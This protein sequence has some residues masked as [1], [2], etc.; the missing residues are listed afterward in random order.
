MTAVTLSTIVLNDAEDPADLLVLDRMTKY[1]R[2]PAKA[3]RVQRVAGGG[4]RAVVQAGTAGSWRITASKVP[5]TALAWLEAH[6][7]RVVCVRDDAGRKAFG[8]YLEVPSED[9][10]RPRT[11]NVD[12]EVVEVTWSEAVT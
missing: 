5:L 3:G 11:A 8:V 4:F 12:L 7:G 1:R 10:A 9:V 2:N 6:Q